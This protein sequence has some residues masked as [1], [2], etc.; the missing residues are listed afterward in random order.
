MA[1]YWEIPE[2]CRSCRNK[3]NTGTPLKSDYRC[4]CLPHWGKQITADMACPKDMKD[5]GTLK[6]ICRV[7]REV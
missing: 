5:G 7:N 1:G 6:S 3:K 2:R 4:F